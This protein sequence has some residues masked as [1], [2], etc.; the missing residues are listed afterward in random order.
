MSIARYFADL[1]D[2]RIDWTRKQS[3]TDILVGALCAV[4]AGADSW[5]AVETFG[6]AD[7]DWLKWFLALPNGIPSHGPFHREFARLDP[8]ASGECV[9]GRVEAACEAA[10]LRQIAVG[11]KAVR[12]A[13]RHSFSGCR[14]MV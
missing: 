14:H 6:Q 9:D 1:P 13:P 8:V 10:G 3:H 5:E 11:V 12:A 4:I 2:P 7:R